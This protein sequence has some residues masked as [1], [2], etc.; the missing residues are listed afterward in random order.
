MSQKNL[1]ETDEKVT[2]PDSGTPEQTAEEKAKAPEVSTP[3]KEMEDKAGAAESSTPAQG[4]EEKEADDKASQKS[5][6]WLLPA[7]CVL[8][9][10][11][12][13]FLAPWKGKKTASGVSG[14]AASL[15]SLAEKQE[16]DVVMEDDKKDNK[17]EKQ[18]ENAEEAR[19]GNTLAAG[20]GT[21]STASETTLEVIPLSPS[22]T[23]LRAR[24][25]QE[26]ADKNGKWSM[27]LYIPDTGETFG[28]NED[29][30]MISASLIKLYIAGCYFEQV[31]KGVIADDYQD[32]LHRMIS[33]SNNES[34]NLLIELLGMDTINSFI[35]EHGFEAGQLNR[36]MLE[37]NGMENYTSS[38]DCARVL[39]EVLE[40]SYVN[41]QA[42]ERI[43]QAMFDQILRNR[44]KIPAGVPEDVKTANKTGELFTVDEEGI[45][46]DVQN[47][48]AIIYAPSHTYVL[49][50][51]TAVPSVGEDQMHREIAAMS[52]EVYEAVMGD[53]E[54]GKYKTELP[55]VEVPKEETS[56][57]AEEAAEDKTSAPAEK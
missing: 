4:T 50:V 5:F 33:E 43:Q 17:E 45:N 23:E 35:K 19:S 54:S 16:K 29:V 56:F 31:E 38:G 25:E 41:E 28:I 10:A 44:Q 8:V 36:R 11:I 20:A 48:A 37:K 22:I 3:A 1:N 40:G 13:F 34:T 42:S 39:R 6:R 2:A 49:T 7:A 55:A 18:E 53:E 12:L 57:P 47:D 15:A 14:E 46:V 21:A 51:M 30:P 9:L 27:C 32:H 26:I 52:A 24:L